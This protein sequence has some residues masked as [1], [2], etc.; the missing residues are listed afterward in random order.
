MVLISIH[1]FLF[2]KIFL[3][4]LALFGFSALCFADPVL[5]THRY[6]REHPPVGVTFPSRPLSLRPQID[7]T[8]PQSPVGGT[9][10][11]LETSGL[12]S[13]FAFQTQPYLCA[14]DAFGDVTSGVFCSTT[15][16]D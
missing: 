4:L 14:L 10:A 5:M 16:S 15:S 7:E 9:T 2:R 12:Q 13:S 1:P 11:A 6:G 8:T 3:V